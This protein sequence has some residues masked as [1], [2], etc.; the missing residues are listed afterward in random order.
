VTEPIYAYDQ[1]K[2][3]FRLFSTE[4]EWKNHITVSGAVSYLRNHLQKSLKDDFHP[5]YDAYKPAWGGGSYKSRGGFFALPRIVFPYITFLDILFSGKEPSKYAIDYMNKYLSKINSTFGDRELCEFI[6]RVYRHGL[7]HTNMPKVASE[8]GKIFGWRIVFDD[9]Q[10]LKVETAHGVS[11]KSTLLSISPKKLAN[12][13]VSSIDEYIR[14]LQTETALVDKF[15]NG[16]LCM[17]TTCHYEGRG[18][19]KRL[20]IPACL[21]N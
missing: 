9:S 3:D 20:I 13:V 5:A 11:G 16:F 6:Y 8:N 19:T 21:K 4:Q 14:D 1:V 15:K 7:A 12:E 18:K 17:A 10:H 2:G